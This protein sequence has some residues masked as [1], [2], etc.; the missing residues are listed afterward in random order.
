MENSNRLNLNEIT[1]IVIEKV[2]IAFNETLK[3]KIAL[4]VGAAI[5]EQLTPALKIALIEISQQTQQ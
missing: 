2:T 5:H 1:Q 4:A 3:D